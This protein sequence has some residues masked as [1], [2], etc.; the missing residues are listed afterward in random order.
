[1]TLSLP[2]KTRGLALALPLLALSCSGGDA[3]ADGLDQLAGF[4]GSWTGT[5]DFAAD[6]SSVPATYEIKREG[7]KMVWEFSSEFA[8][9]FTGRAETTWDAEA[10]VYRETWTDSMAPEPTTSTG[11]WDAE[12]ATMTAEMK[13]ASNTSGIDPEVML[14]YIYETV[15]EEDHFEMAMTIIMDTGQAQ[16]VMWLRMDRQADG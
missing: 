15:L 9:G 6:D 10:A 12:T 14:D 2:A 7:D 16:T 5:Q 11:T 3:P 13:D 4:I 1:M 8:G